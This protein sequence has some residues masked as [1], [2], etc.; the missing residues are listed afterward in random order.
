M[1]NRFLRSR[2]RYARTS[3]LAGN[4]VSTYDSALDASAWNARTL[5]GWPAWPAARKRKGRRAPVPAQCPDTRW[6]RAP[7]PGSTRSGGPWTAVPQ[8][9]QDDRASLRLTGHDHR[10]PNRSARSKALVPGAETPTSTSANEHPL[11]HMPAL[12]AG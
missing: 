9:G 5:A 3:V 1:Q 10:V 8:P 11:T 7:P 12:S 6:T 2:L 4:R